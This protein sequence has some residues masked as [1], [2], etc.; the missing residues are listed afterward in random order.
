M[1]T[2][3]ARMMTRT[4][5]RG[6]GHW[7]HCQDDGRVVSTGSSFRFSLFRTG[8]PLGSGLIPRGLPLRGTGGCALYEMMP[9]SRCVSGF[10]RVA[11]P[12][13]NLVWTSTVPDGLMRAGY[14]G[15]LGRNTTQLLHS[16]APGV[17]QNS[18]GS[19][20]EVGSFANLHTS[21]LRRLAHLDA[22]ASGARSLVPASGQHLFGTRL[23][24]DSSLCPGLALFSI[25]IPDNRRC[26]R[27]RIFSSA[28][29]PATGQTVA[30][31]PAGTRSPGGGSRET[32]PAPETRDVVVSPEQ[33]AAQIDLI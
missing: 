11:G 9:H 16:A 23:S 24:G 12:D 25:R 22:R 1:I 7:E 4:K 10:R 15:L 8:A 3:N 20:T 19:L 6:S 29:I 14:A 13:N 5:S 17:L 28:T 21:C 30:A 32:S 26:Y 18:P 31:L 2:T 33:T 27:S